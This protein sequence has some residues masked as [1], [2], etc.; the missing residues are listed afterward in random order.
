MSSL[1]DKV[2]KKDGQGAMSHAVSCRWHVTRTIHH[3]G[4]PHFFYPMVDGAIPRVT[5]KSSRRTNK[6]CTLC[7][8]HHLVRRNPRKPGVSKFSIH[9]SL[10]KQ[11]SLSKFSIYP[12]FLETR[13]FIEVREYPG[14]LKSSKYSGLSEV[15]RPPWSFEICEKFSLSR[16]ASRE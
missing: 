7:S 15:L 16:C 9:P 13:L 10:L 6:S 5:C 11:P 12:R 8:T 2:S 14:H 3:L 4:K 1:L